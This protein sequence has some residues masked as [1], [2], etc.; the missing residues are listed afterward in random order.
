MGSG[1]TGGLSSLTRD[2][3]LGRGAMA[4]GETAEEDVDGTLLS[5]R[6]KLS[7]CE[8]ECGVLCAESEMPMR[9]MPAAK[10][11]S[12]VVSKTAGSSELLEWLLGVMARAEG[13]SDGFALGAGVFV[14]LSCCTSS[15][16]SIS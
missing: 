14:L 7:C 16:Q 15:S 2:S 4:R 9:F 1:S 5:A 3:S 12:R 8:D 10:S 6:D 11:A 13:P